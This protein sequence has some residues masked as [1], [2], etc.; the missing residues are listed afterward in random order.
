MN[1]SPEVDVT[2]LLRAWENG[3]AHALE[4]LI[5]LIHDALHKLA[6]RYM[7]GERGEHTLQTTALV[8]EAYLRLVNVRDIRWGDRIH[9]FAVS[10]RIMRRI[11]VDLARSKRNHR[12]GG[13]RRKIALDDVAI[14][15]VERS[16]ELLALD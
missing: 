10:A 7:K 12:H 16:T 5:P 8:N 11:L 2:R 3:E 13:A 4:E 9:F 1:A 15:S 14:V 6:R